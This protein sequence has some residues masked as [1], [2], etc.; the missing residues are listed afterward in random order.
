MIFKESILDEIGNVIEDA[1]KSNGDLQHRG[2][3][4]A[5]AMMCALEA[6]SAYGYGDR[7][8]TYMA[9]FISNHFPPDY[10]RH[11]KRFYHL[12]RTSLVHNWNL[13]EATLLP[14][15]DGITDT[16]GTLSFGLLNFFDA[17]RI[18][19]NDLL[20]KLK[21]DPKLQASVGKRY[22]ELKNTAKP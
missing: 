20:N 4:V 22:A 12:Y 19:V 16:G 10:K 6:I 13:F 18:G 5:L 11:A 9:D 17:L 2:H 7:S 8:R 3:V 15:N 14:G 1:K 21:T